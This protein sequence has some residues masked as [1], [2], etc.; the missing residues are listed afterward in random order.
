MMINMVID[1]VWTLCC[2]LDGAS[3]RMVTSCEPVWSL[4][5]SIVCN[6][7]VKG[8]AR[9]MSVVSEMWPVGH[10]DC[11]FILHSPHSDLIVIIECAQH[12]TIF[13]RLKN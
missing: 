9:S 4:D 6:F 11:H 1:W 10:E 12:N 3:G 2:L 8:L 5:V 13:L 7:Q